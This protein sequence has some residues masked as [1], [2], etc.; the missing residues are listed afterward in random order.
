MIDVFD[1]IILQSKQAIVCIVIL[2][3]ILLLFKNSSIQVLLSSARNYT[4]YYY[5]LIKAGVNRKMSFS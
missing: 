3:P 5:H 4:R 1:A 2:S